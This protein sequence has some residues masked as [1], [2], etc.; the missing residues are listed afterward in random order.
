PS[1]PCSPCGSTAMPLPA[2]KVS[3]ATTTAPVRPRRWWR[4]RTMLLAAACLLVLGGASYP[5]LAPHLEAA[6]HWRQA[7]VAAEDADFDQ[8]RT[9]LARCL[10]VWP[11][12]GAVHFLQART[13][14]RAGAFDDA[15]RELDETERLGGDPA[16]V[17]LERA[18]LQAQ[19]G[20]LPPLEQ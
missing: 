20:R 3:P 1:M 8:A 6:Q 7:Q 13:L 19:A 12:S 15:L 16:A 2:D 14:R 9:H 17:A 18:L 10:Q 11:R 5:L 4:P